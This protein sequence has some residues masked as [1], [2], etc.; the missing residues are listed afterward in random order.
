MKYDTKYEEKKNFFFFKLKT[1][2]SVGLKYWLISP[3]IA[4]VN[5]MWF[6]FNKTKL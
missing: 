3:S 6:G 2:S 4:T 1:S 5:S